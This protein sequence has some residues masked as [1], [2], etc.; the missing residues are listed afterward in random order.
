VKFATQEPLHTGSCPLISALT[1]SIR[2]RLLK[3]DR[4]EVSVSKRGFHCPSLSL[5]S[6]IERVGACFLDGHHAALRVHSI[7]QLGVE[8]SQLPPL[9]RGFGFEGAGMGLGLTDSLA[10][11]SSRRWSDFLEGPGQWHKY[12]LHVGLGWMAARLPWCRSKLDQMIAKLDPLLGWLV[13]DGFGFHEGYF[14]C[15]RQFDPA[16]ARPPLSPYGIRAFDQGLGR[17]L[18][19]VEGTD[20]HRISARIAAFRP[21][22]RADMWSGVGLAMAYAGS[23]DLD[24]FAEIPSAAGEHLLHLAQGVTFAAEARELGGIPAAHTERACQL[25]CGMTAS[26]AAQLTYSC[27]P[28]TS[29]G[30]SDFERWR[31]N[32]REELQGRGVSRQ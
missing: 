1:N 22:R 13:V 15:R 26:E 17:S 2:R 23:A 10:I 25:V 27:L 6:H 21:E 28:S 29:N 8:L 31:T 14:H 4:I 5:Q 11:F 20:V 9:Y 7:D 16:A 18:W 32:I 19:F 30:A 24:Q 12:V 3:I